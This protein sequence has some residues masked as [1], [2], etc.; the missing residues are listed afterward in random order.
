MQCA[1]EVRARLAANFR[2]A[3]ICVRAACTSARFCPSSG[4]HGR[5]TPITCSGV[6]PG[7]LTMQCA[8]YPCNASGMWTGVRNLFPPSVGPTQTMV[9]ADPCCSAIFLGMLLCTVPYP[10]I[11]QASLMGCTAMWFPPGSFVSER[12]IT[13]AAHCCMFKMT[14]S[15][16]V[17]IPRTL[18]VTTC[19][20]PV[21]PVG[22]SGCCGV[23]FCPG[24]CP[25]SAGVVLG[26]SC[27]L[28]VFLMRPGHGLVGLPSVVGSLL[29]RL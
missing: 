15:R 4:E 3:Y 9:P 19:K 8:T 18:C 26:L 6:L 21:V 24:L 16:F 27:R 10:A 22:G 11:L 23:V 13:S 25:P 1:P 17:R 14:L 29:R 5:Y 12:T 28:R 2:Y 7:R 20:L